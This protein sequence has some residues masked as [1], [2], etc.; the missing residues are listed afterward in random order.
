MFK[1]KIKPPLVLT[2]ICVIACLLLVAAYEA[3]YT[4]NTGV[5]TKELS[6]GLEEIYGSSE[7][8][9]MLKNGDGAL[10]TQEGV[11]SV[12]SDGKSGRAY[13]ITADG[14]NTGGL[15]LLIGLDETGSVKGIAIININETPGLGTKVQDEKF[16]SQFTGLTYDLMN[17]QSDINTGATAKTVKSSKSDRKIKAVWGTKDEISKLRSEVSSE[18]QSNAFILDAVTGATY[19]SKGVSSAVETALNSEHRILREGTVNG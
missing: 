15:H 7:G 18:A 13:E 16:L 9:E 5:I 2:L 14:Y 1:D 10:M 11:T 17:G 6:A 4:D 8:F 3:T 12:M 19:S